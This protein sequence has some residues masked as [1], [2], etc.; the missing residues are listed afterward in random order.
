[1]EKNVEIFNVLNCLIKLLADALVRDYDKFSDELLKS[2]NF[3]QEEERDGADYIFDLTNKKEVMET[4]LS[5]SEIVK[6][7]CE[8]GLPYFLCNANGVKKLHKP[9]E[10]K[11]QILGSIVEIAE[12][13]ICYHEH[14]ESH[15]YFYDKYIYETIMNNK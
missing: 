2:Y 5:M 14:C 10:I 1:M 13:I 8:E 15:K 3:Y 6:L 11:S 7:Y 4:D 12:H 9:Q